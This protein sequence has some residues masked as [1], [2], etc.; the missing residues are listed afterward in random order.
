MKK[1]IAM[2][3]AFAMTAC[4]LAGCGK[5]DNE[6]PP[7]APAQSGDSAQDTAPEDNTN[8]GDAAASYEWPQ[9]GSVENVKIVE[10]EPEKPLKFAFLGYSNNSYWDLIYQGV[11]G[12]T[13]FLAGHNVTIDQI[14]LGTDIGADV[15][16]NALESCMLQGY[17]GIICT[18]FVTG[19]ENYINQC[20]DAGIPVGIIGGEGGE[21]KR[22][23]CIA[24][25]SFATSNIAA[26]YID[27]ALGGEAG[28]TFGVI[29]AQFSMEV[30]EKARNNAI[31]ILEDKGYVCVGSYEAHDSAD[32]VYTITEQLMTAYPDLGAVYCVSG[33]TYGMPAAVVD[34]GKGGEV[35]CFGNDEIAENIEYVRQGVMDVVGQN[36]AGYAFDA[37]MYL[38]NIVVAGQYPENDTMAA[39]APVI[40]KDNVDELFP[41]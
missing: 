41:Q 1:V 3:L 25:D 24:G 35:Y 21:S 37:F 19:C 18:T 2:V 31:S 23:F 39:A 26:E 6:A 8:A 40:T 32:E 7:A 34:A 17:D 12:A 33:G 10:Q 27:K 13:E 22:A 11:N 28:A 30:T 36:P 15:M 4:L 38:Y 9:V 14:N 20:V 16:N 5:T 29:V